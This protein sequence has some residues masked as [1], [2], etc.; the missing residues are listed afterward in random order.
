M[1]NRDVEDA[2]VA[3]AAAEA[4]FRS[5]LFICLEP[6]EAP[7]PAQLRAIQSFFPDQNFL[8][9]RRAAVA[10]TLRIGPVP[11]DALQEF[12]HLALAG[13]N[14]AWHAEPPNAGDLSRV[15]LGA[16]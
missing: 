8:A 6:V 3:L 15:G 12:A 14:L 11:P 1:T 5:A 16:I 10:G 4:L 9:L 13:S 7:T 2:Q